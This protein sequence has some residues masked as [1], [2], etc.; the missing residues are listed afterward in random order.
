M[1]TWIMSTLLTIATVTGIGM[2]VPQVVRLRRHRCHDGVSAVWIGV[3]VALNGW[4]IAH[5]VANEVWGVAPVSVGGAILYLMAAAALL[6][7]RGSTT[8]GPLAVGALGLGMIPAAF[9]AIG[10]WPLAAV[11]IGLSYGVQFSPA[12]ISAVRAPSVAGVSLATW[13]MALVEAL[14][15]LFYGVVERDPALILGG[16]GG[17]MMAAILVARLLAAPSGGTPAPAE[18]VE[19]PSAVRS[20]G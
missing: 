8:V 2:I 6:D 20:A 11:A 4:W 16:G 19:G 10:G 1:P 5:A 14:I 15:W 17:S 18:G 13:S 7:L 9:L 12:V 3:G